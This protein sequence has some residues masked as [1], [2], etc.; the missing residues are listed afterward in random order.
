MLFTPEQLKLQEEQK[1]EKVVL[2]EVVMD[3]PKKLTKE[4][5]E[6]FFAKEPAS[7]TD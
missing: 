4:E 2:Q 7:F 3:K 6:T 5:E 1:P